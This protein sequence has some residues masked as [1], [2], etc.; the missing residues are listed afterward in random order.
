MASITTLQV[1]TYVTLFCLVMSSCGGKRENTMQSRSSDEYELFTPAGNG[2]IRFSEPKTFRGQCI[3]VTGE[4]ELAQLT[5]ALKQNYHLNLVSN[6]N[7]VA[8]KV[9]S[10]TLVCSIRPSFWKRLFGP[11]RYVYVALLEIDFSATPSS[12]KYQTEWR[13]YFSDSEYDAISEQSCPYILDTQS[14]IANIS[15]WPTFSVL[16]PSEEVAE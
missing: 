3:G 12:F 8:T 5:N 4:T 10:N 13:K 14:V 6:S 9:N 16:Q 11:R 2:P 15:S 7:N 1:G